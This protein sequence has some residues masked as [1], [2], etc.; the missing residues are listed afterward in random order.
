MCTLLLGL[1]TVAR[2]SVILAA[3]RDED[4][5]RPSVPPGLLREQPRV[6]GGRDVLKGGTWLA[7]RGKRAAVAMLNRRDDGGPAAAARRSRGLLALD[8]AAAGDGS[9]EAALAFAR[10]AAGASE[11]APFSMLF[12]S[13]EGC[14]LLANERSAL[15]PILI[16]PGWHAIT[17]A[18]LDD[19]AE[20][21][22]RWLLG[23][24]SRFAPRT[25][26]E[27]E[28]GLLEL[29]RSHGGPGAARD[30]EGAPPVCLHAGPMRT[31]SSSIVWLA[32]DGARYVHIEGRPCTGEPLDCSHLL[33]AGL[34]AR[35]A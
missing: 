5:A 20:P 30:P 13:A 14:W 24:L 23:R 31:V 28:R 7:V 18:D 10:A 29:L 25:A 12:A 32:K 9:P 35:H 33:D 27:A 15:R 16:A 4:P 17:H 8:V 2:G 11:F 3:N 34:P 22:T 6:A 1:D 26:A 21:R 19:T